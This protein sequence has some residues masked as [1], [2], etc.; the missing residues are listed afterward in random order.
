MSDIISG[1]SGLPKYQHDY[2]AIYYLRDGVNVCWC[3][4]CQLA[5]WHVMHQVPSGTWCI[6]CVMQRCATYRHSMNV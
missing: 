3:Q 6:T 1:V 4:I 5:V 2:N